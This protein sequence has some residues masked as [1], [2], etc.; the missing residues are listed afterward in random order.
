[1]TLDIAQSISESTRPMLLAFASHGRSDTNLIVREYT[2]EKLAH[3]LTTPRVGMKDGSYLVRGGVLRVNIR[4]DENLIEAALVIIDGD[5]SFDPETGEIIAGAPPLPAVIE[6]LKEMNIQFIAHTS[7]SARPAEGFWKY[8]LIFPA[9]THSVEELRACVSYILAKLHGRG[10]YIADVRENGVWSQPWYLPRVAS[11][12][13]LAHFVGVSHDGVPLDVPTA[14]EFAALQAKREKREETL[15]SAPPASRAL[16]AD[17]SPIKQFNEKHGL[18]WVRSQLEAQGYRFSYFDKRA[19]AYR[20]IRPG[21]ESGTP[22]VVVMQGKYGDWITYSHHGNADP[23]SGKV[24]DPFALLATFQYGGDLKAAARTLY[25]EQKMKD[26]IGPFASSSGSQALD[27]SEKFLTP[28]MQ[29]QSEPQKPAIKASP[30]VLVPGHKIPP[31]DWLYGKQLIRKFASATISPGGIGKS[32][33]T[34]VEALAMVTGRKL[35]HDE[36]KGQARVWLWNGEDPRDELQRRIA[37]ACKHYGIAQADLDGRLFVDTGREQELIIARRVD[38]DVIVM[39]PVV[40][41][42]IETVRA[43]RI[44]CLIIDPFVSSHRVSENANEEID[45]VGKTWNRIA[46]ATNAAIQLVHHSRKT[47][48]EVT[49]D[50]ARGASALRDTVRSARALNGM[51]DDEATRY[52]LTDRWRYFRATNGKANL[53]PRSDDSAWF[54]MESVP[55]NNGTAEQEGDIIGVVTPFTLPGAFD[56]LGPEK[57]VE[58]LMAIDRGLDDGR[59]FGWGKGVKDDS[60]RSPISLIAGKAEC[61]QEQAKRMLAT[62]LKLGFLQLAPYTDPVRRKESQGLFWKREKTGDA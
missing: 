12:E 32:S 17:D 62:W 40:E 46:D 4:A 21:S 58:I 54:K 18:D 14:I 15:P 53:A 47:P 11:K 8:R 22:G 25:H 20:Y 42:V 7:H 6:A 48:N 3:L 51:T 60:D 35:L 13:A 30:F 59:R 43:N 52:N 19:N 23:L 55:L 57:A 31:R 2:F 26:A 61:T 37:A 38:R 34:I 44:D 5:S 16:T 39:E 1:M 28:E 49:V 27:P 56:D 45:R 29:A 36:P 9:Q 33:L 41:A 10:L 50:D 24:S